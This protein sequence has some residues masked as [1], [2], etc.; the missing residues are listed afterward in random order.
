MT[1]SSPLL[2][3]TTL[4]QLPMHPIFKIYLH[5]INIR[6]KRLLCKR[7]QDRDR[8]CQYYTYIIKRNSVFRRTPRSY[9]NTQAVKGA[10]FGSIKQTH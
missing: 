7:I 10:S 9:H 8:K 5:S 4:T 1:Q 3:T 6:H 2:T